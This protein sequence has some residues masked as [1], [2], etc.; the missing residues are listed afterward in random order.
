MKSEN[1]TLNVKN[2]FTKDVISTGLCEKALLVKVR[3]SRQT[4][5]IDFG[6]DFRK[7]QGGKMNLHDERVKGRA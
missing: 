2:V 7:K 3:K 6:A 1:M 4:Q 5:S